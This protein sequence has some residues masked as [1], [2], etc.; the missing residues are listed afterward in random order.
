M[1]KE[2]NRFVKEAIQGRQIKDFRS[3]FSSDISSMIIGNLLLKT[4]SNE[5]VL[6]QVILVCEL[7]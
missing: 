3:V 2:D 7:A 1:H 5:S 4:N 6:A